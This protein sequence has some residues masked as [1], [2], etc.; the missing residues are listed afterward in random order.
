MYSCVKPLP[1]DIPQMESKLAINSQIIP[2][3]I[4]LVSVTK[5]FTSL[6]Q[7]DQI[8]SN[9][10]NPTGL[11]LLVNHAL[12]TVTHQNKID[13][14]Q[15]LVNG[16]YASS[17]TTFIN[18][19][20]Y[21]LHVYDSV[22]MQEISSTTTM[23][24]YVNVDAILPYKNI[25]GKDTSINMKF[26]INDDPTQ[27]N[28]YFISI[29]KTNKTS[30]SVTLPSNILN[31]FNKSS[32][33]Y[34]YTDN[35]AV[36]GKLEFDIPATIGTSITRTDTVILQVANIA[37]GYYKYLTS[38][39]KTSNVINQLTGEPINLPTNILN[40]HGY[41]SAHFPYLDFKVLSNY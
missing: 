7:Q 12:V 2:N 37:E 16:I 20:S 31:I 23:M 17:N 36:N 33:I 21:T 40:G 35:D 29:A 8:D 4:I 3:Q 22:S 27:N 1:V 24:P 15:Q 11:D 9:L 19:D 13:T 6:Y 25:S 38:F 28:Y 14:L 41:F 5:T 39:K 26:T 32:F 30:G 18:N 10:S 34:L